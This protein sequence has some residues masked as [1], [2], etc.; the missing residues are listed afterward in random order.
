ME[1]EG[2][3]QFLKSVGDSVFLLNT[4]CVGLDGVAD[5]TVTKSNDLTITWEPRD[6][7][8]TALQARAHAIKSALVFVEEALL[9]YIKF[10]SECEN[11][12]PVVKKIGGIEGAAEKVAQLSKSS[13]LSGMPAY[14][15]PL[16]VLLVRW[17]N[18]VV[19]GST[20]RF[21][22]HYRNILIEHED[23][24]KANHAAISISDTLKHFD[25]GSIT[26]KD[27]STMIAVTIR[28]VRWVDQ[29]LTPTITDLESFA[30]LIKDKHLEVVY[31]NVIGVN[32]EKRQKRKFDYFISQNF[33]SI[34]ESERND[35][36]KARYLVKDRI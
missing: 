22:Q 2:L 7:K 21:S 34:S 11:Q 14:W 36:F 15:E 20:S 31:K 32:G 3:K 25:E 1:S 8:A 6:P 23:G 29:H 4:I 27:F 35:L 28:F 5:G 26:L 33:K 10:I 24:I 30:N 9:D 18:R 13:A 17:R 12:A 16:V 19:H